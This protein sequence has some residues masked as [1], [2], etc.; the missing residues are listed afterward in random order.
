MKS[1]ALT[2]NPNSGKTS[3]F[4]A[5]T[6]SRQ[7]VGNWPGVTVEKKEG[8]V[9]YG[10]EEYNIVDLPGTY[11]L[12]AYS[13]DEIVARN[14]IL[15]DK[16]EVV[17]SVVDA[18]NIE[19]NLYL[20]MQLIEMGANVIVA[21]NMMD[22]A[23]K[24]GI[25]VDIEKLSKELGVKVVPTV[26][27][28]KEG[29]DQLLK[30]ATNILDA[31]KQTKI[32]DYGNGINE[33]VKKFEKEIS[34]LKTEINYP[35]EWIAVK[36][37]EKDGYIMEHI[38]QAG[39]ENIINSLDSRIKKLTE[40]DGFEP[41]ITIVDKRYTL[42]SNITSKC[43]KAKER[44]TTTTDKIDKVLT[45]KYLA[46]PIFAAVMLFVYQVTFRIGVDIFQD[47]LD[48]WFATFGEW[49]GGALMNLGVSEILARFIQE[50]VIGGVG[51][52]ITFVPLVMIMYFFIGLL[53]DLGYMSRVAYVM[54]KL[55]R[56][57]GLHGKTAISMIVGSGCNVPG[58]LSTRTLDNK[59]D[60]M[61]AILINPF[62]SCSARLPI[63]GVFIAAFFPGKEALVLFIIYL[64]GILV[65]LICG[66]ILSKTI[67]KGESSYF[68][69]ELPQYRVPSIKNVAVLTWEKAG[70]YF[71][72]AVFV[73]F[74]LMAILWALSI[75]PVGVEQFSEQSILGR[76]G[77]LVAPIFAP[78]GYGNW[79]AAISLFGGIIA[80][81]S[82][83]G[84]MGM[85]YAGVD[86][87]EAL[88]QAIGGVFT[89]LSAASFMV[90][91]LL[92]TPC[93]AALGAVKRE[94]NSWK[95]TAFSALYSF[96][97]AYIVSVLVFQVGRLL[98]FQ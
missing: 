59:K 58:I 5:L 34:L 72:K 81:E 18:T 14:Y 98:G 30:E 83:V 12:G 11:S 88:V 62:V 35:K 4:N 92:Y 74:P 56:S 85:I 2:G 9:K 70:A 94:T 89:Q 60:R 61:I 78:A 63:Y 39:G 54:D 86:Q 80:K 66:K 33:E 38:R 1:I 82:I 77:A 22:A 69:M 17:I 28:R 97:V 16:P 67:F 20:T 31:K 79:Q 95:W 65:A 53:E 6:G 64:T 44:G 71:K 96:G 27:I 15:N 84:T 52:V 91:A 32:L 48:G 68:V 36:L 46:L 75:F 93:V 21:L 7:H 25:K 57:L 43:I 37:L 49:V 51:S 87:G 19:R 10:K 3:L 40:L 55:M 24:Q 50:A 13:E 29:L 76:I 41:E 42:I 26:G 23:E 47:T 73:I 45:N 8:T 90:M